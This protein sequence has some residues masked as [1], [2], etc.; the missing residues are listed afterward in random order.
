MSRSRKNLLRRRAS[1]DQ[2]WLSSSRG[3]SSTK[4]QAGPLPD[5]AA[6]GR[7]PHEVPEASD[8]PWLCRGCSKGAVSQEAPPLQFEVQRVE[9]RSEPGEVGGQAAKKS[10]PLF[11]V[12]PLTLQVGQLRAD[13]EVQPSSGK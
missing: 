13:Y 3:T 10:W 11:R 9:Q 7:E 5:L 8:W 12:F 6:N 4:P 2:R 1:V